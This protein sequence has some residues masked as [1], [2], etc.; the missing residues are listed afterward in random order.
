MG[1][2]DGQAPVHG[3]NR[4][5]YCRNRSS[6]SSSSSNLQEM[7]EKGQAIHCPKCN[8]VQIKK[9]GCDLVRRLVVEPLRLSDAKLSIGRVYRVN[10][11]R[12]F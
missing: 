4:V 8:V 9:W 12:L 3:I 1:A 6:Y 7:I 11:A 2:F 5:H 10:L